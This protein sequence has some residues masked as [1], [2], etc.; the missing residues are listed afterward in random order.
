LGSPLRPMSAE[1]LQTK[2]A[3][4]AGSALEGVL[5]DPNEPAKL[6]VDAARLP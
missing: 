3:S 6:L 5:D 2:T 4:L 1:Q